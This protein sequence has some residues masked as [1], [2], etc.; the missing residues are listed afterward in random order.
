MGK[1]GITP[2]PT[3][4]V[5]QKGYYRP[6]THG[7]SDQ[8]PMAYVT[9]KDIPTPPEGMS[10]DAINIWNSLIYS[11]A[12]VPG[13][14]AKTE[15]MGFEDLCE[16]YAECKRLKCKW[17][18]SKHKDTVIDSRDNVR[19]NPTYQLWMKLESHKLKLSKE[20][21]L[22][23]SARAGIKYGDVVETKEDNYGFK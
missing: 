9:K 1:R 21:G 17:M 11:M 20:Y 8:L 12:G 3:A 19:P 14:L 16:C 13:W 6:G 22:T 18:S 2:Q 4:I 10:K 5:K 7:N 23:P 15:L